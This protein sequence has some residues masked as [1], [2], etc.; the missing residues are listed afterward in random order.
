MPAFP[1]G[2]TSCRTAGWRVDGTERHRSFDGVEFTEV[3][4]RF[5]TFGR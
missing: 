5:V 3:R 4:Y 2:P 1:R